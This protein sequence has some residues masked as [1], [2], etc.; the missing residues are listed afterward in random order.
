ML[1]RHGSDEMRLAWFEGVANLLR[2]AG[3]GEEEKESQLLF[4]F[5]LCFSIFLFVILKSYKNC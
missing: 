4:K 5:F 1:I 2:V 3:G